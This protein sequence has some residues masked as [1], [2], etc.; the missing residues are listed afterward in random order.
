M[1]ETSEVFKET[2]H[3]A[4]HSDPGDR[5]PDPDWSPD[6]ESLFEA[7]DIRLQIK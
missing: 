6:M 7:L 4:H 3:Q 2:V 5:G 1:G